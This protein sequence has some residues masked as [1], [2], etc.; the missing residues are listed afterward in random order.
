MNTKTGEVWMKSFAAVG[1]K[2]TYKYRNDILKMAF[3]EKTV[4]GLRIVECHSSI[5]FIIENIIAPMMP[6][7]FVKQ[8]KCK[9]RRK[10]KSEDLSFVP[11]GTISDIQRLSLMAQQFTMFKSEYTCPKCKSTFQIE[12]ELNDIIFFN[13]EELGS[14]VWEEIPKILMLRGSVFVLAGVIQCIPPISSD[15]KSV[16]REQIEDGMFSITRKKNYM[17]KK[18]T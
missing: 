2:N 17:S 8:S 16:F 10:S 12:F 9:C 6:S 4:D 1:G 18:E 13:T 15:F 5:A 14:T 3:N 11:I 7:V